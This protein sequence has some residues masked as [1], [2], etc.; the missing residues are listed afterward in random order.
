MHT[1]CNYKQANFKG[2]LVMSLILTGFLI[3]ESFC[4]VLKG[5]LHIATISD[6]S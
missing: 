6:H 2:Q 5:A 3:F 4:S 1:L